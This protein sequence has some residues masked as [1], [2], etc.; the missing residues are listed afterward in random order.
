MLY[1]ARS[2]YHNLS[3]G[4]TTLSMGSVEANNKGLSICDDK[5]Q[6]H[7]DIYLV[8]SAEPGYYWGITL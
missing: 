7:R 2:N 6:P 1:L 3:V 5:H 8:Y 4:F